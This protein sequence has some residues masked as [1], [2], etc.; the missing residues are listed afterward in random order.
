LDFATLSLEWIAELGVTASVATAATI[1]AFR[2]LGTKWLDAR[3]AER[4][5]KFKHDQSQEIE[6]LR[7]RINA[8]MD[9][10]TKLHQH[11]FE[12]LPEIWQKLGIAFS[13]ATSFTWGTT[14]YPDLNAMGEAQFSEF[15]EGSP[16]SGW[17]KDELQNCS[18][19][20]GNYQ[21]MMFWHRLDAVHKAHADFHNYFIS[22]G[23]FV[24][25]E[26]KEK[27]R[28]LSNMMYDAF[29]ERETN[30]ENPMPG[31][32]RFGKGDRLHRE[33][34]EAMEAIEKEVQARLWEANKLD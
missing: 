33:G 3:F 25:P 20:N 34:L 18:N 10:T 13:A 19:R 4:L 1:A 24:Q 7:Y 28:A 12:V 14:R 8:L 6:R 22:K 27:I 30:Q 9:R 29:R 11:E 2:L 32:G 17:Q 26:L 21:Q 16:L 15:L 31:E 5:E 23:I